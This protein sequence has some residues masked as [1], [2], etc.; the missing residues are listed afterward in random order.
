MPSARAARAVGKHLRFESRSNQITFLITGSLSFARNA[1][2][3]INFSARDQAL[4]VFPHR[5]LRLRKL[6]NKVSLF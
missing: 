5:K 6:N 1:L 3:S 2:A 4:A